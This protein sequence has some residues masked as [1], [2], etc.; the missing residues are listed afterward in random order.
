[1]GHKQDKPKSFAEYKMPEP[2]KAKEVKKVVED[3]E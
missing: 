3:K 1:M 2:V